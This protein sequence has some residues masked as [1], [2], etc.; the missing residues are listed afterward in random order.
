MVAGDIASG[1]LQTLPLNF[2]KAELFLPY[3]LVWIDK[4][5][6]GL[7]GQWLLQA[8]SSFSQELHSGHTYNNGLWS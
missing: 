7:A 3:Y 6:L 1:R 8:L 4:Y 2:K 5:A